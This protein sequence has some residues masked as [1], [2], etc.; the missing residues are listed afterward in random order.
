M[1]WRTGSSF[2]ASLIAKKRLPNFVKPI[3]RLPQPAYE[4]KLTLRKVQPSIRQRSQ[5][6]F[7]HQL[8]LHSRRG[9]NLNSLEPNNHGRLKPMVGSITPSPVEKWVL[10]VIG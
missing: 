1:F 8:A 9:W 5:N 6:G 4:F 7:E 2:E 10:C 3:N